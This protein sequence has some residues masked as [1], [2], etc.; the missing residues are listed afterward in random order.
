MHLTG[1]TTVVTGA[2]RGI[3][4]A[5]ALRF[6]REGSNLALIDLRI[7]DLAETQSL[8]Q[9]LG[10]E[11]RTYAANVADEEAVCA[12][13]E[14]IVADFGRIDVLVNNAGIVKD[15]LLIKVRDGE[16]ID[17]LSLSNWQAV[18][19]VNLTGVFLCGREAA[20][21]MVKQGRGGVIINISSV[22]RHGN[23]GQ[24]NYSAAK[25]GV[26]SMAVVWAKELARY[27]IRAGAI[28]PGYSRTDILSSMKPELLERI[29][30]PVPAGR[31]GEPEE[32]AEAALFI[33]RND[34]FTGRC[35]DLDGGLRI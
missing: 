17:K 27:G 16:V 30:A 1:C 21:H 29:V 26:E 35:L 25:A 23:T 7:E 18:I 8:A 4:R 34:F 19:D 3:G 24:T 15:A 28:A 33:A 6:A 31:L 11:A 12:V 14:R 32:I 2:A 22:S 9:D 20:T 13:M 10:V 5:M